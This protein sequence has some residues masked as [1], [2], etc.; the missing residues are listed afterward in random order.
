MSKP[1]N[2]TS[3]SN[4]L[5]ILMQ[6]TEAIA[7]Y[8]SENIIIEYANNAML[9]FWG[10]GS[11]IIGMKLEEGVPE[12]KSQPFKLML[13]EVLRTGITNEGVIAAKTRIN[14]ELVTRQ[15]AYCYKKVV[16]PD[17]RA[18]ILHTAADVTDQLDGARALEYANAQTLALNREQQLNEQLASVNEELLAS[19]EELTQT[20]EML[21]SLNADLEYKVSART[22]DLAQSETALKAANEELSA[23]NEELFTTNEELVESERKLQQLL[24]ELAG[25]E[26]KIR[27]MVASAPF[28]IGVYVGREM[29][30]ELVNQSILDV[31]GKGNDV[32]GKTYHE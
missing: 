22:Q 17:G 26:H 25:S 23:I 13:Q 11:G 27:N 1:E 8:S 15:Y 28:P 18:F 24:R 14:G 9:G 7:I 21:A 6:S 32:V 12:L 3:A 2:S 5:S 19:N 4:L 30:I 16:A 29:R 31:W 10:K 20:R